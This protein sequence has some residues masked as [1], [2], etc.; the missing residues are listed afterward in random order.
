MFIR[1]VRNAPLA[2]LEALQM[3]QYEIVSIILSPR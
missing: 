1:L 3:S 2:G